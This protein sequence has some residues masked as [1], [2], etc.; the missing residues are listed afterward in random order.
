MSSLWAFRTK[1]ATKESRK[2]FSASKEDVGE[3]LQHLTCL[4]G[5]PEARRVSYLNAFV[6][7]VKNELK[8]ESLG[9]TVEEILYCL[10]PLCF[11][12]STKI[13]N[14]TFRA[15]RHLLRSEDHVDI[16]NSLKYD[17]L[18]AREVTGG[19]IQLCR[20]IL[21]LAPHKITHAPVRAIVSFVHPNHSDQLQA[22]ALAFLAE[23]AL[24]NSDVFIA[25]GGVSAI[26]RNIPCL[27]SDGM[28]EALIGA[29]LFLTNRPETRVKAAINLHCLTGSVYMDRA[30]NSK[31]MNNMDSTVR[32][33]T[34]AMTCLL[35]SWAGILHLCQGH[36]SAIS[37]IVDSLYVSHL[38]KPILEV[39]FKLFDFKQPEW[40][41]EISVALEA[42]NPSRWQDSFRIADGFVAAEIQVLFPHIAKSRVDLLQVHRAVVLYL[43]LNANIL[44]AVIHVIVSEDTFLSVYATILLGELLHLV[45]TILPPELLSSVAPGLPDLMSYAVKGHPVNIG[46][47]N[48][49][50]DEPRQTRTWYELFGN[51]IFRDKLR[52]THSDLEQSKEAQDRALRAAC[53]IARLHMKPSSPSLYLR[54]LVSWIKS[55]LTSEQSAFKTPP[56]SKLHALNSCE[57][58]IKES[59]VLTEKDPFTWDW[60]VVRAVLKKHD[61]N[62]RK[63]TDSNKKSFIHR[64]CEFITVGQYG[65]TELGSDRK[66][67][68]RMT[69]AG[70]D[71]IS[72]LIKAPEDSEF[73]EALKGLLKAVAIQLKELKQAHSAHDSHL[74]P[75][76]I[77][78]SLC[79][80]YF[81]MIGHLSTLEKGQ[82]VLQAANIY[83]QLMLLAS[84]TNQD[85][86]V[87]LIVSTL[88]F[89]RDKMA[90]NILKK[91]FESKTVSCRMY[92]TK[93]LHAMLRVGVGHDKSLMTFLIGLIVDQLSDEDR[94]VAAM[95]LS[96]LQEASYCKEY[97]EAIV[98]QH[99]CLMRHGDNGL[100]VL[101]RCLSTVEGFRRLNQANFVHSQ[102]DKW[103]KHYNY[104]YVN[105]VESLLTSENEDKNEVFLPP[106]LYQQ[107]ASHKQGLEMILADSHVLRLVEILNQ[108]KCSTDA[109]ILDLKAAL[110]A[111]SGIAA[112][113]DGSVI[114]SMIRIA[115][116]SQVFSIRAVAIMALCNVSTSAEGI[117]KLRSSD[118]FAV[119]HNRHERWPIVIPPDDA[120][121]FIPMDRDLS[122]L[123][124]DKSPLFDLPEEEEEGEES[125][126]AVPGGCT[127]RVRDRRSATLPH[128]S[129]A[130]SFYHNRSY[131]ESKAEQSDTPDFVG[132]QVAQLR[133]D[134]GRKSRS[135]SY[136]DSSTSGESS[137]YGTRHYS[138]CERLP[139]LS[140][141]PSTSSLGTFHNTSIRRHN[142]LS[143]SA[144]TADALRDSR[145]NV[146]KELEQ[147]N[148]TFPFDFLLKS[149]K[150]SPLKP[151]GPRE[152]WPEPEKL[153]EPDFST[154]DPTSTDVSSDDNAGDGVPVPLYMGICLPLDIQSIFPSEDKNMVNKHVAF[155]S[156]KLR[157]QGL[158]DLKNPAFHREICI[159]GPK[160]SH[161]IMVNTSECECDIQPDGH[162][163]LEKEALENDSVDSS[164]T[165]VASYT[166]PL[167]F[168]MRGRT[169]I[170]NELNRMVEQLS[171]PI[172]HKTCKTS[173]L[174]IKQAHEDLFSDVCVFSD[175]S[176]ILSTC[177]VRIDSR[178]FVHELFDSPFVEVWDDAVTF[179]NKRY[180]PVLPTVAPNSN[181]GV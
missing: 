141:I 130:P 40:T 102:L 109:E 74:S 112:V 35:K 178:N 111:I 18:V 84:N 114:S 70:L 153:P 88:D 101:V 71:L 7:I 62:L 132:E 17:Y 105:L 55:P 54:H 46:P 47:I 148:D 22:P 34:M 174:Q 43:F 8:I 31:D 87:K 91:I 164:M 137:T 32:W 128:S 45:H 145:R 162:W 121:E 12:D 4:S 136:T 106:H 80:D 68:S 175:V 65:R 86:Y 73:G 151:S 116:Q 15:V 98:E 3:I 66:F 100:L 157:D 165:D 21:I 77:A 57:E 160:G 36:L 6:K 172:L 76:N 51:G 163:D 33:C 94:N 61:E 95:A 155:V 69:L 117:D 11:L 147:T 10:R 93:A 79:Q 144:K 5:I 169:I 38:Q 150:K 89:S 138:G 9:F 29:L 152:N 81:L 53:S 19:G 110:Y 140:P 133:Y 27:K 56:I 99:P 30:L 131:S 127:Q 159:L 118:W 113:M 85:C 142:S 97:I 82:K 16:Y 48:K 26:I 67:S 92:A 167:P 2:P 124:N 134:T 171:N 104:R 168:L 119:K 96:A 173:L 64:I 25:C 126:W 14:A 115:T 156:N 129:G 42:A 107:L 123:E 39:L 180:K 181:N 28:I 1:K 154:V 125:F 63:T 75:T 59:G 83:E 176:H 20:K 158:E 52:L 72:V 170:R 166:E 13:K 41:D 135:N 103:G 143:H 37:A 58:G 44:E 146:L 179:F 50:A 90:R 120:E 161:N 78:N 49:T 23:L 60:E 149:S 177:Q 24:L 108:G 122:P 139:T